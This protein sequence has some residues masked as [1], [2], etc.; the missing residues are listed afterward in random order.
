MLQGNA[1]S[2]DTA[3]ELFN[4]L[5]SSDTKLRQ[6][7]GLENQLLQDDRMDSDVSKSMLQ[8]LQVSQYYVTCLRANH[9]GADRSSFADHIF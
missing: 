7:I 1:Q 3:L 8:L 4:L 9:E 5:S 6:P 2:V